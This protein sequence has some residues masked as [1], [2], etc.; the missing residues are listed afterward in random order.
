MLCLFIYPYA[1]SPGNHW[2]FYVSRM[3]YSR[4]YTTCSLLD[5]LLSNVLLRFPHV[6]F[7][8]YRSFLPSLKSIPLSGCTKI[9]LFYWC[10]SWLLPFL[11]TYDVEHCFMCFFDLWLLAYATFTATPDLRLIDNLLHSSWQCQQ[12]LNPLSRARDQ[13][14]ILMDSSWVC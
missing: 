12:I 4:N 2:F 6:S 5:W 1:V 7:W 11:M 13:T 8:P 10:I 9:Y 14:H 3:L